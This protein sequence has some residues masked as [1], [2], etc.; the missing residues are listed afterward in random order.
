[1]KRNAGLA[2]GVPLARNTPL[3]RTPWTRVPFPSPGAGRTRSAA[4]RKTGGSGGMLP[5]APA[6]F[7][8]AT[9]LLVRKRAGRGNFSTGQPGVPGDAAMR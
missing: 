2:P 6:E 7:S 1:M 8:P 9:K 5:Q 4:T 3:S